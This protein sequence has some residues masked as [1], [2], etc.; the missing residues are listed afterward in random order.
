MDNY[1]KD[2][3]DE[4][5]IASPDGT[6]WVL[7][8]TNRGA[9]IAEKETPDGKDSASKDHE[10]FKAI[11]QKAWA[12]G[13]ETRAI[14]IA[15]GAPSQANIDTAKAEFRVYAK[16]HQAEIS[17]FPNGHQADLQN[18]WIDTND[19]TFT[20]N[21]IDAVSVILNEDPSL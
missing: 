20:Q 18:I 19:N 15:G 14:E 21:V 5:K 6:V 9:V 12:K 8:V 4:S 3:L 10:N 2:I 17:Q 7:R 16:T 13:I 1:R 11:L